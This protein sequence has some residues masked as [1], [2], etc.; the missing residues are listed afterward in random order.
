MATSS[1]KKT[2]IID[3]RTQNLD[4]LVKAI[5]NAKPLPHNNKIIIK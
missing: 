2:Y 5:K 4:K 1:I 3:Q